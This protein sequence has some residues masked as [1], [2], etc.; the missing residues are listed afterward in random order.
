[1][2]NNLN[3]EDASLP[4][5]SKMQL[6][7]NTKKTKVYKKGKTCYD[8]CDS[9]ASESE[10][11]VNCMDEKDPEEF[12]SRGDNVIV[13]DEL[14]CWPGKFDQYS[15]HNCHGWMAKNGPGRSKDMEMA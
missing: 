9:S 5:C 7:F 14:G 13:T 12:L 8:I 10:S 15:E 3:K 11:S 4:S 2:E 1:M 6:K